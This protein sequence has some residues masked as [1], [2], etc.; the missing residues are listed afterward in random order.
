MAEVT[1]ETSL[2]GLWCGTSITNPFTDYTEL[3]F[4]EKDSNLR[5]RRNDK[6][7]KSWPEGYATRISTSSFT[8]DIPHWVMPIPVKIMGTLEVG[9]D[10]RS[11]LWVQLIGEGMAGQENVN[12]L[13]LKAEDADQRYRVS[14]LDLA[15]T[16][17]SMAQDEAQFPV[18]AADDIGLTEEG[19]HLARVGLMTP[20]PHHPEIKVDGFLLLRSGA[21]IAEEYR[22]GLRSDNRHI[23]ASITKSIMALLTGIAW[24][25]G[26]FGL[27]DI[28]SEAF[29]EYTSTWADGAPIRVKHLLSLTAG[30]LAGDSKRLLT[31]ANLVKDVLSTSRIKQPGEKY[32][33]NNDLP[34]LLG[35]FLEKK[36]GM[37]L[38]AFAE[39][40][41]FGPLV[42]EDY[43]WTYRAKEKVG[44]SHVLCMGGMQM[45]LRDMGRIGELLLGKGMWNGNRII[46]EDWIELCTTQHTASGQYPYGF[47]FHL[48]SDFKHLPKYEDAYMA[49]GS[50]EQVICVVPSLELVFVALSSSYQSTSTTPLILELFNKYFLEKL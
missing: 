4:F 42:V 16:R 40:K 37:K 36:T 10:G 30:T 43:T 9:E 8:A 27:E 17:D 33:Y 49:I 15:S 20:V 14:Q 28:V 29:P 2:L 26:L 25:M 50:G 19:V 11:K 46:S 32:H 24:D 48:N 6:L 38:E 3:E 13:L 47:F 1:L 21:L 12:V 22:W 31:S 39:Q 44:G 5:V 7:Q 45:T 18:G 34:D 41:L 23:V 35:M